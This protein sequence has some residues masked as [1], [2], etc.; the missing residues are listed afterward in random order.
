[1]KN[2][3]KM[4]FLSV[5]MM[6]VL[7]LVACGEETKSVDWW[8]EHSKEANDKYH[9]CIASDDESQNCKNATEAVK[10]KEAEYNKQQLNAPIPQFD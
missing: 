7:G 10:Q 9:H 6:S 4:F 2:R 8:K 1:M 5:L 3:N